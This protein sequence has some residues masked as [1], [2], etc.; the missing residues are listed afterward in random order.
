MV[1]VVDFWVE[2]G[3][4]EVPRDNRPTHIGRNPAAPFGS[5][6]K[7]K[8]GSN[9]KK[10]SEEYRLQHRVARFHCDDYS[11]RIAQQ[12]HGAASQLESHKIVLPPSDLDNPEEIRSRDQN[13]DEPKSAWHWL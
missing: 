6:H 9:A 2:R 12:G 13:A 5:A 4:L 11:A 7:D 3:A 10:R 1:K 8:S